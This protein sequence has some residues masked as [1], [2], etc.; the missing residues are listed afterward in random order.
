[1]KLRMLTYNILEGGDGRL[2]LIADIIRNQQPD[3]VALQEANSQSNADTLARDLDMQIAF[4]EANSKFHIAWL[5][6]LP[7]RHEKNHRL[8]SL[9]KTLLEIEVAW[10]DVPLHLFATHL[11]SRWEE[12]AHPRVKEVAAI[13]DTLRPLVDKPHVLVGDFNSLGPDD[14]VGAAPGSI[15]M[16]GDR[17]STRLNSSHLGIS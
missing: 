8:G 17:K 11:A 2:S 3:V 10:D 15:E 7:I 16:R 1:M 4:G 6:R 12:D 5:S 13:L 14:P 9:S